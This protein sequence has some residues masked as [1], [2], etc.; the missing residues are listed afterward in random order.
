M[1]SG[2]VINQL[3]TVL[4][5]DHVLTEKEELAAYA[6]DATADMPKVMPE[7]VVTPTTT[8]QVQQIVEIA[9]KHQVPLLTRGSGTNLSGGTIPTQ[10]GIVMVMVKLNKILEVDPDN[11]TATMQPGVIIQD[12]NEAVAEHG[13][14]YPPDPGTV[15]TAT[16]GGSVAECSGGLRGLKYGVT[17]HYIM[18]LEVVLANGKIMRC[19]GKT[20]KN[21]TAYDMVK[22]FVGSE[23]TLG[24]ITEIIVKLIPAPQARKSAMATFKSIDDAANAITGIIRNKV[25]PATLEIMDNVTIRTVEQYAKVGLPIDAEAIC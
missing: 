14:M 23:G 6:F 7:V 10:K 22:L 1:L 20:V 3:K 4:G 2:S 9:K 8:D 15:A 25:I 12:L 13:L 18:G 16:M 21:V 19:G 17:K 24:V 11:L 5:K